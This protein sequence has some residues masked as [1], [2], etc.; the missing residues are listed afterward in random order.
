MPKMDGY[1]LCRAAKGDLSISHIPIILLT[2]LDSNR[3]KIEG[4]E[5]GADDYL[6]KPFDI[7]VLSARIKNLIDSRNSLKQKY[8]LQSN[9]EMEYIVHSKTDENF[10]KKAYGI[11]EKHL[12][13]IEF[14]AEEFSRE[15]GM[16]RSNLHLKIKA[17][18]DQST[19][20]FIRN[21]R[22][23]EAGKLLDT[24]DY[25][26]SEVAYMVG[27]NNI[28]YFNR[29]FKKIYNQTPSEYLDSRR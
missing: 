16:S 8:L 1:E 6:N 27:F 23:K 5:G 24:N 20:E 10:V 28:S 19:T 4:F 3:N 2:V 25:N 9:N 22:L 18:T 21:Y 12:A 15:M 13:N 29:C 14:T 26:I 11:L 17:L 7:Y